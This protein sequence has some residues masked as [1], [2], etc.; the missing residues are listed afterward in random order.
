M[1]A[2]VEY[3]AVSNELM[4][5]YD[6]GFLRVEYDN[7]FVSCRGE[8][9]RLPRAEFLILSRLVQTPERIVESGELWR[10]AWRERKPFNPVSLHVYMYRLR[11]KLE[12]FGIKIET[13]IGIGYRLIPAKSN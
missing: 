13:L 7:Y 4:D 1:P 12:P 8:R 2:L 6:D 11:R 3:N 10:T 9:I 5:C